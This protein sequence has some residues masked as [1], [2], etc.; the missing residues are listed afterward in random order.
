MELLI[1]NQYGQFVWAAFLFTFLSCFLLYFKT[2]KEFKKQEKIHR[3]NFCSNEIFKIL[4]KDYILKIVKE[5]KWVSFFHR[6][7][8]KKILE[9]GFPK[10]DKEIIE[11][12]IIKNPSAT[13]TLRG[14]IY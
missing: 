3:K 11:E 4:D 2:K 8:Y 1:L 6:Y 12:Y 14:S 5:K 9:N 13:A 10:S 7:P